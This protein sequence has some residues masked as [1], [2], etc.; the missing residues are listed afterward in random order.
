VLLFDKNIGDH[1]DHFSSLSTFGGS[2]VTFSKTI[3]VKTW[4]VSTSGQIVEFLSS[5]FGNVLPK[6]S[7]SSTTSSFHGT[8]A[9]WFLHWR[10]KG[11]FGS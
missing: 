4:I 11:H 6:K 2:W 8:A 9:R 7:P 5:D 3:P 10:G 1:L